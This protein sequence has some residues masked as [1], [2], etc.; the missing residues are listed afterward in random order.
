MRTLRG[1]LIVFLVLGLCTTASAG[2]KLLQE[3]EAIG[4]TISKAMVENDFELILGLYTEDAISLPNYGVRMDG[5]ESFRKHREMMSGAGIKIHSFESDPTEA[6]ESGKHVIEIGT[7]TID[8]SMPGMPDNMKDTGKYMTVYVREKGKL[9][10]KAEMWNTDMNP[11]TMMG[12]PGGEGGDGHD[13]H[14]HEGHGH[15]S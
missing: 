8:M 14:G 2:K 12:G 9:K 4:D 10:I 7:F 5:I 3:V 1:L 15:G 13:E 6:W 11:M